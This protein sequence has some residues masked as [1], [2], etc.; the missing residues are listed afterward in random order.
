LDEQWLE[1]LW[2]Y[3]AYEEGGVKRAPEQIA[4]MHPFVLLPGEYLPG[5]N[6][7]WAVVAYGYKGGIWSELEV[8]ASCRHVIL[9]VDRVGEAPASDFYLWAG[10]R[11]RIAPQRSPKEIDF[12]QFWMGTVLP[13]AM[14][15]GLYRIDEERLTICLA[16]AGHLRPSGFTTGNHP[17]QVLGQLVRRKQ[18]SEPAATAGVGGLGA[19]QLPLASRPP[20]QQSFRVDRARTPA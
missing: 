4:K 3:T 1:G 16:E 14:Q 12:E 2:S 8:K 18:I 20:T 15:L 10:G 17:H 9:G 7:L 13:S 6:G 5:W 19:L 11:F